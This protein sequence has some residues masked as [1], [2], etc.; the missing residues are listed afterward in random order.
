MVSKP[1]G[2]YYFD[3][4]CRLICQPC[5]TT[6]GLGCLLF[7]SGIAARIGE[8]VNPSVALLDRHVRHLDSELE[9][10]YLS[11]RT[12]PQARRKAALAGLATLVLWLGWLRFSET[13]DLYWQDFNVVEPSNGPTVDLPRGAAAGS[14]FASVLR[15][16]AHEPRLL[17]CPLLIKR[18]LDT[19]AA[20]GS[21]MCAKV[22]RWELTTNNKECATQVFFT[23]SS[24]SHPMTLALLLTRISFP[25][26]EA[27]AVI[28][29]GGGAMMAAF[30][31]SPGNTLEAKFWSLHCLHR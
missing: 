6:D 15:P 21:I 13:F 4:Q 25:I 26:P 10:Q 23:H 1:D 3:Q 31:G 11:A 9:E 29:G 7:A 2:T 17:T 28:S 27:P 8:N 16:K 24:D 19:I 14:A 22:V 5:R 20:S 30:D 18:S 12:P